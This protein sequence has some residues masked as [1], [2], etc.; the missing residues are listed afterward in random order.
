MT[1]FSIPESYSNAKTAENDN[2]FRFKTTIT[3]IDDD[4]EC[5]HTLGAF[6]AIGF[7][8]DETWSCLQITAGPGRDE[9]HV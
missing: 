2:S 1:I 6:N 7:S 8:E 4:E 3:S 9:D 5:G